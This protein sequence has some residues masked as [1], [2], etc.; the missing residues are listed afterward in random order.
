ME[1]Y[2]VGGAVRDNILGLNPKDKDYVVVDSS[3]KEMLSLG[4]K[5]VGKDFP[6]F[7]HPET[8]YEY[9]LARTERKIG[10][11]YTG[12]D[13]D[14]EGVTL[15]EDLSRRDLTINSMA[16]C[17]ET[18]EIIDPFNG[19]SDLH[20]KVL[21]HTT[22]AFGEDPLRLLRVARFL[23]RFGEKWVIAPETL[24]LMDNLSAT[25]ELLSLT[26]ERVWKETE[27]ALGE[28]V[29]SLYFKTLLP[30]NELFYDLDLMHITEQR[31]DHHPEGN[32]FIHTMLVVDYAAKQGFSKEEVFSCLTHDFGK[33]TS[34]EKYGTAHGH[35]SEGLTSINEFCD[36]WKVPNKYRELALLVCEYHTKIHGCLGRGSNK[37]M[38]AKSIMKL[39]ED[40]GAI[41]K[42]ERFKQILNCCVADARG[43]GK[44]EVQI[45]EFESKPYLQA[46]YLTECLNAVINTNTKNISKKLLAN[47]KDGVTIGLEI[48]A[49][50]IKSIRGVQNTWV[51]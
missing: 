40:T 21:R 17:L 19:R 18:G 46:D 45:K 43:R 2:L 16:Q 24:C 48:R 50:R 28:E 51:T 33:Y 39:F 22:E 37:G 10:L 3:P 20:H 34:Q 11:G 47:G 44:G 13:C 9:A 25:G 8:G 27:K 29:P 15:L 6:V 7:L 36:K 1:V 32:V 12:F 35:E 42:P 30:Y 31:L 41:K 23:A 5:E 4:Y 38:R 14:W 49:E 26:P